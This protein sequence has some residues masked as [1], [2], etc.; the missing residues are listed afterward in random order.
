MEDLLEGL[1]GPVFFCVAVVADFFGWAVVALVPDGF[2]VFAEVLLLATVVVVLACWDVDLEDVPDELDC[3]VMF[4]VG[5]VVGFFD[6]AVVA[7]VLEGFPVVGEGPRGLEETGSSVGNFD[8]QI[9]R[10]Q[11]PY[12]EYHQQGVPSFLLFIRYL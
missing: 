10:S 3:L 2:P 1:E 8:V 6:L 5:A 12:I 4:G 11:L 7:V 9:P